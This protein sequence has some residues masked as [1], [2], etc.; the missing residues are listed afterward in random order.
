M[1]GLIR[2]ICL[3]PSLAGRFPGH[4]PLEAEI[5]KF[6]LSLL[7]LKLSFFGNQVVGG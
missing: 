4:F 6:S 5:K 2:D 1:T 7:G 3:R